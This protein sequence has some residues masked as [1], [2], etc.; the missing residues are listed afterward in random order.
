MANLVIPS[1]RPRAAPDDAGRGTGARVRRLARTT[2][3]R[4]AA[5]G[6][7]L[8]AATLVS[9]TIA[10]VQVAD[11]V[12]TLETLHGEVEPLAYA[13]QDL[14]SSL[15]VADAAAATA[16]ISGGVEPPQVRDRYVRAIAEASISL[17]DAAAGIDQSD[18]TSHDLV[19]R[20]SVELPRY[21]GLVETARA[22]NR[23]WQ[24]V[25]SAYLSEASHLMQSTLLPAADQLHAVQATNVVRT[26]SA[27][28]TPPWPA[29]AALLVTLV[30][31]ILAQVLLAHWTRRRLNA[32]LVL[33]TVAV[34]LPL[35]WLVVAGVV[36]ASATSRALAEG[37]YPMAD[38]TAARILTQQ[39]R[40]DE[41]LGLVRRDFAGAFD[42][43]FR[44]HVAELDAELDALTSDDTPAAVRDRV[45]A[46][47][48][49]RADWA[50]AHERL[51]TLLVQGDWTGATTVA[52][53]DDPADA[54]AHYTAADTNLSTAITETR[55][56]LRNGVERAVTIL[57]GLMEGT[58]VLTG[59]A[60]VSV[61]AGLWPRLREY[62]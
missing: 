24:P 4:L 29:I 62:R 8:I 3:A 50:A 22:H 57:T 44:R 2:P 51:V 13:A 37:A 55:A 28:V 21:T 36:S 48:A 54:A 56:R 41:T 25:G 9:G 39:A 20:L 18:A 61:T 12:H 47:Q 11:R 10:A 30:L 43:Q 7:A 1:T 52:V 58:L 31:L 23:N 35:S 27:F 33:A 6:V 60:I 14:Y 19:T 40:S 26:Q 15:S 53:G 38:L 32:G 59:V 34:A 49:A 5:V 16:F 45:V 42:N 17:V 46:A